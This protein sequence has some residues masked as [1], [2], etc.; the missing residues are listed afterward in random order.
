MRLDP[1][2]LLQKGLLTGMLLGAAACSDDPAGP[3][4]TEIPPGTA[5]IEGS[6]TGNRTFTAET[7][8]VLKG[9]VKVESGAV[10]TIRPGTKIVGDTTRAGSSLFVLRGGKLMAEGTAD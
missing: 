2:S 3:D 7:T 1:M 10:L 6:I 4:V 5:V 8:Y 9:F